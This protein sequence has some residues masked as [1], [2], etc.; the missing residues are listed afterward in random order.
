MSSKDTSVKNRTS[1]SGNEPTAELKNQVL[2]NEMK[3]NELTVKVDAIV[4]EQVSMKEDIRAVL[5]S[6]RLLEKS[7]SSLTTEVKELKS[8]K[9]VKEIT[10][11]NF[12]EEQYFDS[13]KFN[14]PSSESL[15]SSRHLYKEDSK[16]EEMKRLRRLSDNLFTDPN[17]NLSDEEDAKEKSTVAEKDE[18]T[19]TDLPKYMQERNATLKQL[20]PDDV[21]KFLEAIDDYQMQGKKAVANV[22]KQFHMIINKE[23]LTKLHD[24]N[25]ATAMVD[26]ALEIGYFFTKQV[27]RTLTVR[28]QQHLKSGKEGIIFNNRT[29]LQQLQWKALRGLIVAYVTPKDMSEFCTTLY[30]VM[31]SRYVIGKKSILGRLPSITPETQIKQWPIFYEFLTTLARVYSELFLWVQGNVF[32]GSTPLDI[33]WTGTTKANVKTTIKAI[34]EAHGN[35][36]LKG[37]F[38][39]VELMSANDQSTPPVPQRGENVPFDYV[40]PK[41]KKQTAILSASQFIE[42]MISVGRFDTEAAKAWKTSQSK[43]V[44]LNFN[45]GDSDDE[46]RNVNEL[47][48]DFYDGYTSETEQDDFISNEASLSELWTKNKIKGKNWD[49]VCWCLIFGDTCKGNCKPKSSDP[50]LDRAKASVYLLWQA[51]K[52]LEHAR[53]HK[54]KIEEFQTKIKTVLA[55][56]NQKIDWVWHEDE[57]KGSP[58]KP[59]REPPTVPGARKKQFNS[60]ETPDEET[61]K[62]DFSVLAKGGDY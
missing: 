42:A 12:S 2:E 55:K 26:G 8:D 31:K 51:N 17:D 36:Y 1:A 20:K 49:D 6:L 58:T 60:L 10:S 48:G 3:L 14:V 19:P 50:D 5:E 40:K 45:N 30:S 37:L 32:W 15:N 4:A 29:T 44:Q 22:E 41:A 57:A 53:Q 43:T 56:R 38:A 62:D 52:R 9:S 16:A 7:V 35:V 13:E 34:I 54:K 28:N 21:L 24:F 18:V 33:E 39:Q 47:V 59:Q 61:E 46:E 25:Y 11:S 23:L 27:G